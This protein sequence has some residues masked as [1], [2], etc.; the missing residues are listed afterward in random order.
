MP[1][2][3]LLRHAKSDHDDP[4]QDDHDRPLSDRGRKDAPRMGTYIR[5]QGWQPALV[6]CSTSERTRETWDLIEPQ[7]KTTPKVRFDR[8]I[9]LAAWPSLVSIVQ[10]APA[11]TPS[12]MVIGHNPG[13][14]QL[15]LALALQPKTPSERALLETM[16]KKYPTCALAVLEFDGDWRNVK[17]GTG[18]L[19]AFVRPKDIEEV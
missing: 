7:L 5:D 11:S 19:T 3:M 14:E 6:I 8:A 18:R 1:T 17:A 16:S 4:K 10:S 12:L 9:Y 15:A 2:L 13:M